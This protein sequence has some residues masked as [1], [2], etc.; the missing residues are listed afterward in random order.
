MWGAYEGYGSNFL[1]NKC[2][3]LGSACQS[4]SCDDIVCAYYAFSWKYVQEI[5]GL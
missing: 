1:R 2:W 5:G 3:K 4:G